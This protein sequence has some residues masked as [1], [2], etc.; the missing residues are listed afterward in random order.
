M[1]TLANCKPSEFLRQSNAIR[2]SVQSWITATDI[3]NIRK[4]L[5]QKLYPT[6]EMTVEER[7]ELER[8]NKEAMQEQMKLNLSAMLDSAL[9]EHA[10]ETLELLALCCFIDPK[11]VD[12]HPVR[13]YL[14]AFNEL[15]NDESV[16][17]FFTSL[18]HLVPM[19]TQSV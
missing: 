19:D 10:E 1:K 7:A 13:D 6:E 16:V 2:K 12:N 18:L 4:R 5:P 17:G 15:I 8:R 9:D 11:D 3:M 14:Q